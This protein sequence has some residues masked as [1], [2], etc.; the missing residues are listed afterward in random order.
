MSVMHILGGI[1]IGLAVGKLFSTFTLRKVKGGKYTYMLVGI[2]GSFLCDLAF[3]FLFEHDLVTSFFY[4]QTTIIFEM[5]AG[6]S[7]ACYILNLFGKKETIQ[8]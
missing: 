2:I 6:A 1:L 3:K 5:I 8:F 7:I 4:K